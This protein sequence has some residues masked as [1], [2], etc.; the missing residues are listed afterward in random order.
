MSCSP[1][2]SLSAPKAALEAYVCAQHGRV[3]NGV[4][5]PCRKDQHMYMCNNYHAN[6]TPEG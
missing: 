2:T 6:P 5:V 4:Q 1:T 3:V